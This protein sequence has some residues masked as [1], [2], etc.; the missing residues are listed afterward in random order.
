M[1]A[2]LRNQEVLG[3]QI[4][5]KPLGELLGSL[6]EETGVDF[7]DLYTERYEVEPVTGEKESVREAVDDIEDL[8]D[9]FV[10]T[11]VGRRFYRYIDRRFNPGKSESELH[12]F[13]IVEEKTPS[14][15]VL[16]IFDYPVKKPFLRAR[17]NLR[18]KKL[19]YLNLRACYAVKMN[20]GER[21]NEN[22]AVD[23]T[24]FWSGGKAGEEN[25]IKRIGVIPQDAGLIIKDRINLIKEKGY[26]LFQDSEGTDKWLD[27]AIQAAAFSQDEGDKAMGVERSIEML[28]MI[29]DLLHEERPVE[30]VLTDIYTRIVGLTKKVDPTGNT[31]LEARDWIRNRMAVSLYIIARLHRLGIDLVPV[32]QYGDLI[33]RVEQTL[34]EFYENE[35]RFQKHRVKPHSERDWRGIANQQ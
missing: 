28:G 22:L 9:Y 16:A 24:G 26:F 30:T 13:L 8:S 18:Q 31:A 21:G 32:K 17:L 35:P 20:E 6:K 7:L 27:L 34:K 11:Y 4:V 19:P 2:S 23:L 12:D 15:V 1:A 14:G 29:R 33:G 25:R 5:V 10:P 3:E